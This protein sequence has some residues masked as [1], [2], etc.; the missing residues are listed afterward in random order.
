MTARCQRANNPHQTISVEAFIE[1]SPMGSG[2]NSLRQ[3]VRG[4]AR[5]KRKNLR[6]RTDSNDLRCG[7]DP[8]H[9]RQ[10]D[11]HQDHIHRMLLHPFYGVRAAR[12]FTDDGDTVS[13][14]KPVPKSLSDQRVVIDYQQFY[15]FRRIHASLSIP[16]NSITHM[17]DKWP[18]ITYSITRLQRPVRALGPKPYPQK[19]L[20]ELGP[21]WA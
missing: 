7:G 11:I 17:R 12:S 5:G 3:G 18:A 8:I 19:C 4:I 13:P 14:F 6:P 10:P 16:D 20:P 2:A 1:E 15:A 21:P 9:L